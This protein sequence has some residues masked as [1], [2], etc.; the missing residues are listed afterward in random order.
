M[1]TLMFSH[2]LYKEIMLENTIQCQWV[3]TTAKTYTFLTH[4]FNVT[5]PN[6]V[7]LLDINHLHNNSASIMDINS[8]ALLQQNFASGPIFS[9]RT[10][11]FKIIL[12]LSFHRHCNKESIPWGFVSK[13]VHVLVVF[14]LYATVLLIS[15]SSEFYP[16]NSTRHTSPL[17]IYIFTT[18]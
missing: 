8:S 15:P 7:F 9:Q 3:L 18:P 13:S 16:T 2:T 4:P 17:Y 5:R 1:C 14:S 6:H 10:T 12:I 11:F